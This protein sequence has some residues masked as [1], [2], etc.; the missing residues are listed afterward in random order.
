M[1]VLIPV[2]G[3]VFSLW[4]VDEVACRPWNPGTIVRVISVVE[5]PVI[6]KSVTVPGHL[7]S[8]LRDVGKY[9]ID[10]ALARLPSGENAPFK[11]ESKIISGGPAEA[12]L[13]DAQEWN[14]DLIVLGSHGLSGL[15]R[16]LLGSV[17]HKVAEHAGCSVELVRRRVPD[18]RSIA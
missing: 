12:I 17:S 4:A 1:R 3:S 6:R 7:L 5:H 15:Q 18:D 13:K 10:K 9:A 8:Q 11:V 2:D 16:F 14:A